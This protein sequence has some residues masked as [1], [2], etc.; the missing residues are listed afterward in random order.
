MTVVC[1]AVV[2]AIKDM[3]LMHTSFRIPA[4]RAS[5]SSTISLCNR[6]FSCKGYHNV[7]MHIHTLLLCLLH[8]LTRAQLPLTYVHIPPSIFYYLPTTDP[9]LH[10]VVAALQPQTAAVLSVLLPIP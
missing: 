1:Y 8:C 2:K 6:T 3:K 5:I 4:M 7:R 9:A 10:R